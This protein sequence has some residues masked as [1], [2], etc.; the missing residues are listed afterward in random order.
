MSR[1]RVQP[2]HQA[3]MLN[4]SLKRSSK[5]IFQ[6]DLSDWSFKLVFQGSSSTLQAALSSVSV[7]RRYVKHICQAYLSSVSVKR[8]C[9]AELPSGS[10]KRICQANLTSGSVKWICQVDLLN[11]SVKRSW[12]FKRIFQADLSSGSAKLSIFTAKLAGFF[13]LSAWSTL[14]YF[15]TTPPAHRR[16]FAQDSNEVLG[17]GHKK[18]RTTFTE[19]RQSSVQTS[20]V[21]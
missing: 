8:N 6:A 9:Q 18:N 14:R 13:N 12:Y 15:L 4:E 11:G 20:F 17:D 10:A 21:L 5:K 19:L 3:G 2:R 7:K 1:E 16:L